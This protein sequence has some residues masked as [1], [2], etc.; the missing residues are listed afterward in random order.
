MLGLKFSD[1]QR[2][3]NFIHGRD[4]SPLLEFI[5]VG[6]GIFN[7][8]LDSDEA[9]EDYGAGVKVVTVSEKLEAVYDALFKTTYD[10]AIYHKY[11]GRYE[12]NKQN[13]ELILRTASLFSRFT[14]L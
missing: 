5:D 4:A 9:Y 13:K 11:V 7:E 12:F 10:G 1:A 2:Y 3:D 6:A 14:E 8:L